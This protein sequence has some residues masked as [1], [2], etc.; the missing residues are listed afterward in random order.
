MYV[1]YIDL[2]EKQYSEYTNSENSI[3]NL[4]NTNIFIGKNN[5]GKS[6]LIRQVLISEYNQNYYINDNLEDFIEL[7]QNIDKLLNSMSS[8]VVEKYKETYLFKE[9]LKT[10]VYRNEKDEENLAIFICNLLYY[11]EN[12]KMYRKARNRGIIKSNYSFNRD[13]NFPD[14]TGERKIKIKIRELYSKIVDEMQDVKPDTIFFPSFLSLRKLDNIGDEEKSKYH[15]GLSKMFFKDY[16]SQLKDFNDNIKTGQEIYSDMKKQLLGLN[17]DRKQFLKYEEYVSKN[18]F[19]NKEISIFIKDD[20]NNIYIKE[21]NEKEY[22]IYMLGDGMQTL[23]TITYYLFMNNDKP[24]KVFIDEPEVHLHP[25]LQRLLIAKLQEYKNCQFFISTHSSSMIDICDEYDEKTSI[26]CVDKNNA[27]KSAYNS[28]YNNMNLYDLI[29]IRPSSIILSNC[30]IWVEGPTDIYYIDAFLKLY[31]KLKNNRKF[32]LGYNYNYA[33]NGSINIASKID[34]DNEET[35]TMKINKLSKN[36]F[37]IFDNDN[38]N[39]ENANYQK[40]Q[41]LKSK[42]GESC[43]VI[44]RLK[45]IE[46][47]IPPKILYEYYEKNYTSKNKK[48]KPLVLGFFNK[49]SEEYGN[50]KYFKMDFADSMAEYINENIDKKDIKKYTKYCNS[51]WN[52]NKYNL[53]VYFSNKIENMQNDEQE[54][55]FGQTMSG[56]INMIKKIYNFIEKNN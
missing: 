29:G 54:K 37:I 51:L 48:I 24:L 41:N 8:Y 33:F 26:I 10:R 6:R 22:P 39:T 40:I 5:S 38:L 23:I 56:F 36:N 42:L 55:L 14:Y 31:S 11:E 46:N 19:N 50:N 9:N 28:A 47:I 4:E 18:F 7:K 21:E 17:K 35:A 20:D 16:F 49:I 44:K 1:K 13:S 3:V 27:Q 53:A 45:T 12:D 15:S 32:I 30:T 52:S 2:S 25:G 34:F 43:Y